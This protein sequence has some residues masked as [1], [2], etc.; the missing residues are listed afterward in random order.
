MV[1]KSVE[2]CYPVT[3]IKHHN[4]PKQNNFLERFVNI[5]MIGNIK[6]KIDKFFNALFG[7]QDF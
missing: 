1:F 7:F 2:R 6:D 5:K 3:L 4:F